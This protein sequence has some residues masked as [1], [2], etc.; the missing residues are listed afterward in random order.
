MLV[1]GTV[2]AHKPCKTK[3]VVNCDGA[4]QHV[5]VICSIAHMDAT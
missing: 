4:C 1:F 2:G 5:D 3:K